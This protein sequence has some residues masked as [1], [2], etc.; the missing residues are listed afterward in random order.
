MPR[1][2][3]EFSSL[4]CDAAALELGACLWWPASIAR[5]VQR[6]AA[7]QLRGQGRTPL[8]GAMNAR[9][10]GSPRRRRTAEG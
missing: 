5:I 2:S 10:G 6:R 8:L 3:D 1:L 4:A 9:H 7:I